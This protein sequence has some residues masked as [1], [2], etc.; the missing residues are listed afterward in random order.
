MQWWKQIWNLNILDARNKRLE[1]K[2]EMDTGLPL[3]EGF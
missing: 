3:G 1:G 2:Y